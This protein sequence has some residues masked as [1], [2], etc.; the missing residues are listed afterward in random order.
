MGFLCLA[1]PTLCARYTF[2]YNKIAALLSNKMTDNEEFMVYF[3]RYE[4][5]IDSN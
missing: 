1:S 3:C 5:F 2:T 4:D